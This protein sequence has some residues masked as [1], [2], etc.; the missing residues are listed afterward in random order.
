MN[1]WRVSQH[2]MTDTQR[3]GNFPDYN[4]NLGQHVNSLPSVVMLVKTALTR[5]G[6]IDWVL[7]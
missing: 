6:N 7:I 1:T 5:I 2:P 3:W 4:Q